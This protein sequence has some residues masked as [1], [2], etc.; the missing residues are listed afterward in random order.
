MTYDTWKTSDLADWNDALEPTREEQEADALDGGPAP[1]LRHGLVMPAPRRMHIR[2][3]PTGAELRR[4]GAVNVCGADV[5]TWDV[6]PGDVAA[7]QSHPHPGRVVCP[8]CL[9]LAERA[10]A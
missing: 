6:M 1:E 9:A 4:P 3:I 8:D 10:C 7:V 2:R 5:T